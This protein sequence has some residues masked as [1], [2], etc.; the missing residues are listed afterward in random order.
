[1]RLDAGR[2]VVSIYDGKN[3]P[4]D[5]HSPQIPR[6]HLPSCKSQR[7]SPT[8]LHSMQGFPCEFLLNYKGLK[9]FVHICVYVC[10]SIVWHE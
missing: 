5:L 6:S 10:V 3:L 4:G 1:M 8:Q 2:G 9:V 7:H